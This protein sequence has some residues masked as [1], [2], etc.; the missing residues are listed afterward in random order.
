VQDAA[1]GMA[2]AAHGDEEAHQERVRARGLAVC[3]AERNLPAGWRSGHRRLN[4]GLFPATR[5]EINP[6]LHFSRLI[7]ARSASGMDA[8]LPRDSFRTTRL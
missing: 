7:F 2:A 4:R 6:T 8:R 1:D 5:G 3:V